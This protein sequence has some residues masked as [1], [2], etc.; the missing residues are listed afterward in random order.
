MLAET[1]LRAIRGQ[2]I[3]EILPGWLHKG[4]VPQRVINACGPAD[5]QLAL[6]DDHTDED[7]FGALDESAF[8]VH[9][10]GGRSRARFQLD[11]P[12]EV[13]ETLQQLAET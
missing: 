1:E 5:F 13:I 2:K 8:T 9:V 6:G 11:G 12:A 3:V 4:S 7:L 10:G